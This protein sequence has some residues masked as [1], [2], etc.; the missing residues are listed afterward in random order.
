MFGERGSFNK[1]VCHPIRWPGSWH[2]KAAPRLCEIAA[3]EPDREINLDAALAALQ[4]AAPQTKKTTT[5]DVGGS[6]SGEDFPQLVA[7]IIS[8]RNFHAP[9][10]SLAAKLVGSGVFDGSIVKL[11][12]AVMLASTAEH[13][14]MRWQS[15]FDSSRELFHRQEKNSA[16]TT[17]SHHQLT[18]SRCCAPTPLA[19]L[20]ASR[21]GAGCTPAITSARRW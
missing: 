3:L 4:A 9:L 20:P 17:N 12:R 1:P 13:D 6:G 19:T 7:D 8:G 21:D 14:A 16:T 18:A 2:R 11:L 15:R 5:D 10:V